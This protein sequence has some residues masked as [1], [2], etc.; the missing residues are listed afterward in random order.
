M[1]PASAKFITF[2]GG[3]GSGK[4]TQARR[5]AARLQKDGVP[6]VLT[7]EPGGSPFAERVRAL[8][9]DPATPAHGP[10]AEALLFSAARADH[11]N[12]AIRPALAAGAWVICDRF[13]DSTRV[14]QGYAGN[15]PA[16]VLDALEHAIIGETR[17]DLTLVV[18]M[19][20]GEGLA[21]AHARRV[22]KTERNDADRFEG[23][24]RTFHETLRQGFLDL[25]KANPQRCVVIDGSGSEEDVAARVWGAAQRV[26]GIA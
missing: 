10:L 5:L 23:R 20:V 22:A 11:L 17:P 13:A 19:D 21:R 12:V 24:D 14:Y 16:A 9:L 1:S 4:S 25:A 26:L 3:E 8:L 6:T 7:R 2:E 18:D 15:V